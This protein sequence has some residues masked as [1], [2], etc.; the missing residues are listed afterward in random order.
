MAMIDQLMD[1]DKL[2]I[3]RLSSVVVPIID[4][5]ILLP[6]PR[7]VYLAFVYVSGGSCRV[8]PGNPATL[9]VGFNLVAPNTSF[10]FYLEKDKRLTTRGWNGIA[11]AAPSTIWIAEVLFRG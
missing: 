7:R 3:D 4:A 9:T 2:F 11:N 6:E 10:E 8:L 1:Y 5:V